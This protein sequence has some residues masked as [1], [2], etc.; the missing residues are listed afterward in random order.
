MNNN[1]WKTELQ[2]IFIIITKIQYKD[3]RKNTYSISLCPSLF[4]IHLKSKQKCPEAEGIDC[5]VS[6]SADD[7]KLRGVVNSPEGCAAIQRDLDRL[8][9][10]VERNPMWFNKDKCRVLRLSLLLSVVP[11]NRTGC[12][13]RKL[14]HRKFLLN[15]RNSFFTLRVTEPGNRLPRDVVESSLEIFKT[16][17]D[18][19]LHNVP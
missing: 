15:T 13:E 10:L 16:H 11:S 3:C 4:N 7:T 12:N 17:L 8:E 1:N 19:L 9:S 2:D 18:I 5:S 14:E 6:K